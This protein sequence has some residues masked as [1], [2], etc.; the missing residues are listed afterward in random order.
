MAGQGVPLPECDLS[1]RQLQAIEQRTQAIGRQLFEQ[2]DRQQPTILQRRWWDEQIMHWAMRDAELKT[3]LFRFVDVLPMLGSS[4]A[5]VAHLREHLHPYRDRLPVAVRAA[6]G[7][8]RTARLTRAAMARLIRLSVMDLARRF[9]AGSTIKEVLRTAKRERSRGYSFTLDILGEIVTSDREADWYFKA[10]AELIERTA[11]TV[12]AWP[13]YNHVD[14]AAGHELP[15]LNLSIKLSALDAHFDAIDPES[16]LRR[17]GDRLRELLRL[18]QAHRAFLYVDMESYDKKEVTLEIFKQILMEPEFR[19]VRDVGIAIQCYLRE[20]PGDLPALAEWARSRGTPVWVRLVKGAY[21]DYETIHS[22]AQNWPIPVYCNKWETDACFE[23]AVRFVM[24]RH[25]DLLP[26]LGSH[27]LRSLAHGLATA[28]ILELPPDLTEIQMLYGMADAEKRVFVDR[29]NRL[30][31]YMPFGELIPGMAYLVRR[32]LENTSNQSFLRMGFVEQRPVDELM[33]NPTDPELRDGTSDEEGAMSNEQQQP[34]GDHGFQNHPPVD[35]AQAASRE[36]MQH[37]LHEVL[38]QLGNRYPLVI[39]GQEIMTDET[40]KS[41]DPSFQDRMVGE[42]AVAQAEHVEQAVRAAR[43]DWGDWA[44]RGMSARAEVLRQLAQQMRDRFYELAAWEIYECGKGWREA[45]NDVC[46][47][48]DFCEYYAVGAERLERLAGAAVPGEDNR[49]EYVPRG[50]TAVIAPWNFPLAILTG[51]TVAA[52]VTGN[53]VIMKPAEQSPV[54]AALLM[55]MVR[56]LD[57]PP[58]VLQYLPG[59]GEVAG[60]ALVDHPDVAVIAFTGSREVGLHIHARAAQLSAERLTY[61]K[62]VIAEMGGKNAIIVAEDADLD[63]AVQGVVQSAFGF[64]GQ[65]CSACSRLILVEAVYENFMRRLID[66][67]MSLRIGPA[68]RPSTDLGPLIDQEAVEKVHRYLAIGREE[69]PEAVMVE[70]DPE[71]AQQGCYVAPHIFTDVPPD[72]RLAQ[73]EIFGPVLAVFKVADFDE[74]LRL[75]NDSPYAL[76]GGVYA[77]SPAKL[78]QAQRA[79]FVGNLYL[80]RPITGAIVGRQPF[81]GFKLSG[82]G[83]KAGGPDYLLQF[84][85]ARTISENTMRR[86]FAPE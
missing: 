76:T 42:V 5:V 79:F 55:D 21:W 36:A 33:R 61:V 84:V 26:A 56:R 34:A 52:L 28:E 44:R 73:E 12:L 46:E 81:G 39:D 64:Q 17:V 13:D 11:D 78:A 51:M 15:R 14:Q 75:A 31:V 65:K 45:T 20:T 3:Q 58:G 16:A 68:E 8:G 49:W 71:L 83:S 67:T 7:I 77:R 72:G 74:A 70:L 43:R 9:I 24:S 86:G 6:M 27:N 25:Q 40:M 85:L 22:R 29:G 69:A 54:T 60:A 4:D 1:D 57:V 2:T 80:N 23:W 47:A 82:I 18:A 66:A 63:E 30:R 59:R 10:Y 19:D 37:A 32:L 48:I 53:P 41:C 50:V 38:M 35:F 62:R